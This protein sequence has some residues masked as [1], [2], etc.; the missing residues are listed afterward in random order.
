[1]IHKTTDGGQSWT[2]QFSVL[3]SRFRSVGF[4]DSL[5]GFVGNLGA[6]ISSSITDTNIFYHYN[7][8]NVE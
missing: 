5:K 6:G 7:F 8:L 2:H 1:M 3:G 4:V